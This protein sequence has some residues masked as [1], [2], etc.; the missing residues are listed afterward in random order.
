MQFESKQ[1]P[2]IFSGPGDPRVP[3]GFEKVSTSSGISSSNCAI[4]GNVNRHESRISRRVLRKFIELIFI[5][6]VVN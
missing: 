2:N 3:N 1:Q 5:T 4:A 6:T